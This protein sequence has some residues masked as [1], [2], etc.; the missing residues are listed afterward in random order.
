VWVGVELP[1]G[2]GL[3]GSVEELPGVLS[4]SSGSLRSTPTP[5]GGG[6]D[7]TPGAPSSSSSRL[8]AWGGCLSVGR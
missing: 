6:G 8:G 4:L 7:G 2:I 3:S 5:P 1:E